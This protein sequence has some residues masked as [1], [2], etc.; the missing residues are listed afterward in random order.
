MSDEVIEAQP[1]TWPM[2]SATSHGRIRTTHVGSLPRPAALL[3]LMKAKIDG[4]L[5]TTRFD[6]YAYD[7]TVRGAV[8][9]IVRAQV[10]NGID[11]VGD[12]EIGRASCRE[13]VWCLV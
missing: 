7:E 2:T 11:I 13:R 10:D 3:D 8:A 12:G 6:Q 4:A 5:A 1:A 9:D